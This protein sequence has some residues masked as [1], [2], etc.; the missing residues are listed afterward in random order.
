MKHEKQ[1]LV[2]SDSWGS[3]VF[4]TFREI[5]KMGKLWDDPVKI[6]RAIRNGRNV[7]IESK[8]NTIIAEEL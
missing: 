5:S 7:I 2:V 6:K 4:A 8:N 3:P 1:Y